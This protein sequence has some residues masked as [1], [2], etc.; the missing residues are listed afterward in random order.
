MSNK[1]E[2]IRNLKQGNK[3]KNLD[4]QSIKSKFDLTTL[5]LL[6]TT[7][8]SL[9]IFSKDDIVN[10]TVVTIFSAFLLLL[11]SRT[12][13]MYY[14]NYKRK[15]TQKGQIVTLL[16]SLCITLVFAV[17]MLVF[18]L[19]VKVSLKEKFLELVTCSLFVAFLAMYPAAFVVGTD[20]EAWTRM[21]SMLEIFKCNKDEI[22]V[23]APL[24]GTI[25]GAWLSVLAIPLDW[26]KWWQPFP[27]STVVFSILGNLVGSVIGIIF[28]VFKKDTPP[29][30]PVSPISPIK[31]KEQEQTISTKKEN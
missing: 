23:G 5:L 22:S 11:I 2:Q 16:N 24:L 14:A 27:I 10:N 8:C 18:C 28:Y 31:N 19:L 30:S 6:T 13:V 26:F 4:F 17:V 21:F 3:K 25:I 12:S 7:S 15:A 9:F 1:R 29:T 20:F